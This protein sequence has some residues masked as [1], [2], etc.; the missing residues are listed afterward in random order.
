M[1]KNQHQETE[2]QDSG[3]GD[4]FLSTDDLLKRVPIS[5]GTLNNRMKDGT[6]PFIKLGHRVVF[7]WATVQESLLRRQRQAA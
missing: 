1:K 6:I 7:D 5:R 3:G 2:V 4:G